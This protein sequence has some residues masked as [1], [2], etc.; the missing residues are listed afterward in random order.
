[1]VF[2]DCGAASP[3]R[4]F[5]A[6]TQVFEPP[7]GAI[8][9]RDCANATGLEDPH[10][11]YKADPEAKANAEDVVAWEQAHGGYAPGYQGFESKHGHYIRDASTGF[12]ELGH[13]EDDDE[14]LEDADAMLQ[15]HGAYPIF[16]EDDIDTSLEG[17]AHDLVARDTEPGYDAAYDQ[18]EDDEDDDEDDEDDGEDDEPGLVARNVIPDFGED[19]DCFLI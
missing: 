1:M 15:A 5:D 11:V 13:D 12:D 17:Y 3:H 10:D 2:P 4:P 7:A 18:D 19:V 16:E 8:G 9:C 14:S 6:L